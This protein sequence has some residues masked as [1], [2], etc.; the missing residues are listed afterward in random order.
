MSARYSL[1]GQVEPHPTPTLPG[2]TDL[3]GPARQ[4]PQPQACD[5]PERSLTLRLYTL[6][7]HNFL[8]LFV[9]KTRI[10]SKTT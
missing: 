9:G 8:L 1:L 6:Q 4:P 3:L 7:K 5:R 10:M 2:L